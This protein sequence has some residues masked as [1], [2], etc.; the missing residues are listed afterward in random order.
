MR[1]KP[2]KGDIQEVSEHTLM[3]NPRGLLLGNIISFKIFIL[4]SWHCNNYISAIVVNISVS[5]VGRLSVNVH[6]VEVVVV[7]VYIIVYINN[8]SYNPGNKI[9]K[10]KRVRT[11]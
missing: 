4:P 10:I 5:V 9:E 2:I 7:I 6:I 3:S 1:M 8:N 11:P